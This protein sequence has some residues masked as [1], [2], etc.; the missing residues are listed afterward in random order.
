MCPVHGE[1]WQ[2]PSNHFQGKGCP[3]CRY[4][5]ISEKLSNN[6]EKFIEKARKIHGDKY[7]YS[8]VEYHKANEKVCIIC[9]KHGEFLQTPN[10]HLMGHGCPKC[11]AEEITKRQKMSTEQFIE[12]AKKTHGDKY[13]YSKVEYKA[14]NEKVCIVCPKHGEFL[15]IPTYH[16]TNC[17]CPK[18]SQSKLEKEIEFFLKNKKINFENSKHFKWLNNQ[19]LDFYLPD[20]NIAIECQGEQHFEAIK[21]FGG[22][23]KYKIQQK[24]DLLKNKLCKENGIKLLYYTNYK[25]IQEDNETIFKNKENLISAII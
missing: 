24:R 19:H 14:C 9:P 2:I 20:Y 15:Q 1:F 21:H 18:C 25:K 7:D 8:K 23:N 12:K 11:K 4:D 17:G 22:K 6:I 16:L 3:K 13:D 5:I 10:S